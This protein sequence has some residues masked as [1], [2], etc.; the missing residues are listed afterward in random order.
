ML[1]FGL[2]IAAIIIFLDQLS[3]W[4]FMEKI[5]GLSYVDPAPR[6]M[7]AE[8]VQMTPFFN[9]VTVWN[10][11][12]SFGILSNDSPYGPWALSLLALALTA[13]LVVWL[14]KIDTKWLGLAVGLVIG[15]AIG[16]VLD[17]LRFG[18]VFDFLDFHVMGYHWPAF[19]VADSCIFIGVGL[20][21]CDGLFASKKITT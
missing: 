8:S 4:A 13:G 17:R 21:L 14:R 15:G 3:K 20:I 9:L 11:G 1:R 16:N 19:N 12:V 7:W 10:R 2:V 5:F 18:A 6:L